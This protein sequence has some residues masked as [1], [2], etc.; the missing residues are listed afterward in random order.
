MIRVVL[1]NIF[2]FFLPTFF[3]LVYIAFKRNDWPGLWAILKGAPLPTLFVAGAALMIVTLILFSSTSG[4]SP[5]EAYTPPSYH[6]GKV[7]PGHVT[8]E[9]N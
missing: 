6:N 7:E 9:P 5:Q 8:R 1:E 4:H 3:Y 2:Y